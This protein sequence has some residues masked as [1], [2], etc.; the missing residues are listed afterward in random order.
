VTSILGKTPEILNYIYP[1]TS[2]SKLQILQV[3]YE[4]VTE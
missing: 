3:Y 2:A 1:M 4:P